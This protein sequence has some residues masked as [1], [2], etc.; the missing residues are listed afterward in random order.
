[1][2]DIMGSVMCPTKDSNWI[3]KLLFSYV[4]L[5]PLLGSLCLAGYQ[6]KAIREYAREPKD[7]MPEWE[8]WGQL[9]MDG[10]IMMFIAMFYMLVPAI[11]MGIS[12]LP[13]ILT[14]VGAA[15]AM[16][17]NSAVQSL[18]AIAAIGGPVLT[19]ILMGVSSILMFIAAILM[20]MA[21][22]I[23]AVSG[24]F[25][26]AINPLGIL[27]KVLGNLGSY[28]MV[29]LVPF[30][31]SMVINIVLGVT[32]IGSLLIFPAMLYVIVV[33]SKMMGDMFRENNICS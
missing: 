30:V 17:D 13:M 28:I 16:S 23:Y 11:L 31:L 27:G 33:S 14:A 20:P 18:S 25:F 9:L 22:G 21:M 26:A 4:A 15:G 1:M 2:S 29:L 7:S 24:S 3:M 19:L 32:V 10:I 8:D 5:I 12:F 6:L